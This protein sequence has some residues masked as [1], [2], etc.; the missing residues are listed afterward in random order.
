[1]AQESQKLNNND[2]SDVTITRN[3]FND[4]NLQLV[5]APANAICSMTYAE[6][7]A[8]AALLQVVLES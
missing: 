8:L 3:D 2:G 7:K 6:V 5:K 4:F 1:M